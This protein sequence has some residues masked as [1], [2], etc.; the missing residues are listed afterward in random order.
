MEVCRRA[1]VSLGK[2]LFWTSRRDESVTMQTE[3]WLSLDHNWIY[4][5]DSLSIWGV[6][7]AS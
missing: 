3:G 7:V 1:S 6:V 4:L 5:P 2:M